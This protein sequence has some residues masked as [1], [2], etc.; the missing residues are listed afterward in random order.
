LSKLGL[1][2]YGPID[3]YMHLVHESLKCNYE[4][5]KKIKEKRWNR[6]LKMG[7]SDINERF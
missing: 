7:L 4:R 5:L 1:T 3:S 2:N 6:E